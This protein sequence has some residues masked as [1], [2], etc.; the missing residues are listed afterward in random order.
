MISEDSMRDKKQRTRTAIN[1]VIKMR[2]MTGESLEKIL[3]ERKRGKYPGT[4]KGNVVG[5]IGLSPNSDI[6]RATVEEKA[7]MYGNRVIGADSAAADEEEE[8]EKQQPRKPS[9]LEPFNFSFMPRTFYMDCLS[10]YSVAPWLDYVFVYY[11][12]SLILVHR[13]SM[14]E[15]G[16]LD[17]TPGQG[18][19][20]RAAV[21]R[22][23]PYLGI[24]MTSMHGDR[25]REQLNHWLQTQ[26]PGN[27]FFGVVK[28]VRKK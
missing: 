16:V 24:T 17:L 13:P 18:E 11:V 22:R 9:D 23:I 6:W 7:A 14:T 27:F 12:F 3:P 2:L 28:L 5:Y 25:L 10:T 19:L 26:F 21:E 1:Q 20:C 4:T 15:V 8:T